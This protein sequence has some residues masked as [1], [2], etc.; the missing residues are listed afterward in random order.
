MNSF[1]QNSVRKFIEADTNSIIGALTKGMSEE[2]F[3]TNEETLGSWKEFVV[4]IKQCLQELVSKTNEALGWNIL[5]E[6]VIP[7]IR[8]R[9]D[10]VIIANDIV[11][12]IE[13]KGGDQ[14]NGNEALKQAKNYVLNLSDF[15]EESRR[16]TIIP[17]AYGKFNSFLKID[18]ENRRKG[19][20]C[21]TQYQLSEALYDAFIEWGNK[22][23]PI[24]PEKWAQS[25]YFPVPTIIEAASQIYAENDI[26]DLAKSRAGIEN[27]K[28]TQDCIITEVKQARDNAEKILIIVTG[29]PGAGKTLAGLNAVQC[30]LKNLDVRSEQASFLSGNTPLVSVLAEAFKRSVKRIGKRSTRSIQSRIRNMHTFVKDSI[31]QKLPP[32]ERLIVFDEAQRAWTAAKNLKKF[33]RDI[34]EPN[35]VL[36]IMSRHEGWAAVIALVGGGQEIHGGEAGLGA[37]GDAI[38]QHPGWRVI[39][40][41]EA[42]HGGSSVAGATLF[43]N[44]ENVTVKIK[45]SPDLH[46]SVSK[47]SFESEVN[48]AWVNALLSGNLNEA[49]DLSKK[50]LSIHITRNLSTARSWL[51]KNS[52]GGRRVG[53]I[54]SSGA[55]RLR[56]DGVET[57]TFT[58]LGGIDYKRWFLDDID[59]HRSSN[60][61]EVALSEFE[62]QGLEI[63][64]TCLLWGGDLIF[65]NNKPKPRKLSQPKGELF[66][67]WTNIKRGNDSHVAADDLHIRVLNKYRVLLTRFRKEMIIYVPMGDINDSTRSPSDFD[68]IYNYLCECGVNK[69]V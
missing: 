7:M 9:I 36:D 4:M 16:L 62:L 63:D 33:Q 46:L 50:G 12:V 41:P 30:I 14:K 37:W 25:R 65:E 17:V 26:K 40:S 28:E 52:D 6:Y 58:F 2:G 24:N 44:K 68:S 13:F 64:L 34:S 3:S 31:D 42:L 56:A 67:K 1:Y 15:H 59:D 27:L 5:L 51:R 21:Q 49:R 29:V 22:S 60:Q 11:F 38:S 8:D 35:A 39:T 43:R 10:C 61:L 19:A 47:R 45:E 66:M 57:P 18:N 69:V 23:K 20:I 48:A 32:A 55:D 53:L 54:A